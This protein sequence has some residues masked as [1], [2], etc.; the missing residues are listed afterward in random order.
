[1]VYHFNL[2]V[3][4]LIFILVISI[5]HSYLIFYNGYVPVDIP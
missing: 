5:F 2:A 4:F 1:M 3:I